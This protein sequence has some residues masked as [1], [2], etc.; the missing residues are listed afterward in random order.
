MLT[1]AADDSLEQK[2]AQ[3]LALARSAWPD[4]IV[5]DQAFVAYLAERL[6]SGAD[7]QSRL[8][9]LHVSDLYL[10]CACLRGVPE[11]IAALD[12][13]YLSQIAGAVVRIGRSPDF[14]DEV[15]Q[16][17]RERILVGPRPRIIDYSG[18]GPLAGWVRVAA[19]RIALNTRRESNRADH[20]RPAETKP[21]APSPELDAIHAQY[22]VEVETALKIALSRLE[23]EQR[24]ALRLHYIE[25]LNFEKI[26][27]LLSIDRSNASRRVSGAQRFLLEE[28][29][30][31]LERLVPMT[32]AS[33]DSLLFALKSKINI[34]LETV[35]KR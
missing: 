29:K 22:R 18:S 25:G 30:R 32:A 7:T 26:G 16:R 34:N 9:K 5:D 2:L 31:E 10:A 19:I 23:P 11:A 27:R 1:A 12:R 6:P 35:L 14:I 28:T 8:D 33:R 15:R 20:V 13:V 4:V 24:E 3:L 17:L 21:T